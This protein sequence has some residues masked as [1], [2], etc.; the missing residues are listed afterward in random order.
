MAYPVVAAAVGIVR[1]KAVKKVGSWLKGRLFGSGGRRSSSTAREIGND[2]I[3][4]AGDQI[5]TRMTGRP[6]GTPFGPPTG[7]FGVQ[8]PRP[9]EGAIGRTISRILPGGLTGYE[10][11]AV[12]GTERDKYGRAIA[13]HADSREQYFAP[14]G[15]VLVPNFDDPEG[16]PIAML[17]GAA[18]A[19]GLWRARP[20]PPISGYDARAIRRASRVK[21]RVAKLAKKV[22]RC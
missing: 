6:S 22:A 3:A 18:I 13:Y 11:T 9:R 12:E 20:K 7:S 21:K 4:Y 5:I 2:A 10:G 16:P 14:R 17:R 1:S 8:D 19:M 15:Y